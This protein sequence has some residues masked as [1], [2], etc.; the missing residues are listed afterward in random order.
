M[1]SL[2]V[3]K[4]SWLFSNIYQQ[5]HW[6]QVLEKFKV[7]TAFTILI[8]KIILFSFVVRYS[9]LFIFFYL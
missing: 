6:V 7:E 9:S 3:K 1:F 5:N 8:G 4:K 2:K